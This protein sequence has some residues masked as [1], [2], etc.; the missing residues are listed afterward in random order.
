VPEIIVAEFRETVVI[1]DEAESTVEAAP[2]TTDAGPLPSTSTTPST[3]FDITARKPTRPSKPHNPVKQLR[4]TVPQPQPIPRPPEA[5]QQAIRRT[6]TVSSLHMANATVNYY[7]SIEQL[8]D[9][10]ACRHIAIASSQ[11]NAITYAGRTLNTDFITHLGL[12]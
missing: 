8:T 5:I 4:A 1:S 10:F 3:T 12:G 2:P 6:K 7:K 9:E 11:K